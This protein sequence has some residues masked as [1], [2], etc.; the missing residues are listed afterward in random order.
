MA[1]IIGEVRPRYAF[2]ENSPALTFRG[3]DRVLGDL[4]EMG[5]DA[6]WGV[7]SAADVG[8]PHLRERIWIVAHSNSVTGE[9]RRAKPAQF[10]GGSWAPDGG[11]DVAHARREHGRPRDASE[12]TLA[13]SLGRPGPVHDQ[14]SGE[15]SG[16]V[17]NTNRTRSWDRRSESHGGAEPWS[18]RQTRGDLP[19]SDSLDVQGF[20]S[21]LADESRRSL[22]GERPSGPQ[23][24]GDRGWWTIEPD[25]GRVAHGVADR[26]HRLKAIGNGQV[27]L[28]AAYAFSLLSGMA[29]VPESDAQEVAR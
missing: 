8:A 20:K 25:V 3:L 9:P 29:D 16:E 6:R 17:P 4:A 19:D 2:V 26:A 10:V 15:G 14:P 28:V 21:G 5:Y 13:A 11:D 7:V 22:E 23:D 24:A 27:P 1:R 18:V 12:S